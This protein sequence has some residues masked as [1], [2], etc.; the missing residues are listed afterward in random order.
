MSVAQ[1][2]LDMS[3]VRSLAADMTRVDSRLSRHLIP[4]VR[5]GGVNI[6]NAMQADLRK[7]K[8]RGFKKI[9]GTVSFDELDGGYGV[10]VGPELPGGALENVAYFGTYKGGGTV[11]DPWHALEDEYP[12]FVKHLEDIAEGLIFG[13]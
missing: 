10:E 12:S 1:F 13:D 2:Q 4:V 9:A 5:K 11:R 7:S 6:K 8:N 3:E